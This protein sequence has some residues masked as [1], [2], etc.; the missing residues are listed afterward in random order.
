MIQKIP[1]TKKIK[2][3]TTRIRNNYTNIYINILYYKI[4]I[5]DDFYRYG[6]KLYIIT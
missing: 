3:K 2:E 6:V 5:Q 1:F 4:I